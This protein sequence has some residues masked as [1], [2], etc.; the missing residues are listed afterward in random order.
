MSHQDIQCTDLNSDIQ[1]DIICQSKPIPVL[2][3]QQ[4]LVDEGA[5]HIPA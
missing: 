5:K 3:V 1:S 4:V 2:V